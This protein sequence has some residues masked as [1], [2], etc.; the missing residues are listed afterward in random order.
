VGGGPLPDAVRARFVELAGGRSRARVLVLPNASS[1]PDAGTEFAAELRGLGA[2][3][4]RWRPDHA[5]ADSPEAD[6]RLEGVTGV[7]FGG[8]DQSRLTRDIK[9]TR[10]ERA[11]RRLYERGGVVGGT[12]AGAAVMSDP[13]IT[14]DERRPGGDRPPKEKDDP[15]G[16][17]TTIE[18]NNVVTSPGFGLLP[19][20][21]VDQHFVRRRRHNRLMSLVLENP[22]LVGIGIDEST[23][24]EVGPGDEWRV[25]G[26]NAI[27]VYDARDAR[28]GENGSTLGASGIRMSVLPAGSRYDPTTGRATLPAATSVQNPERAIQKSGAKD[29]GESA[30]APQ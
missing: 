6:R 20:A 4:E 30:P 8:G 12:S 10:L 25:L 7:W 11:I 16:A 18:R 24:L 28:L 1:D 17:F 13:M 19:G 23:A 5:A 2:Q 26:A 3:A 27:V 22:R 15:L 29:F 21:I 9:G 14:G